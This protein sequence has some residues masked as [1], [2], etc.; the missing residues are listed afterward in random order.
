MSERVL[1]EEDVGNRKKWESVERKPS[2]ER[3][4]SIKEV[5]PQS[6]RLV[7]RAFC[8]QT[9]KGIPVKTPKNVE[10]D[11]VGFISFLQSENLFAFR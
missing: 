8:R 4:Q 3:P 1:D 7:C 10:L 11:F 2:W 5:I 6:M 9:T